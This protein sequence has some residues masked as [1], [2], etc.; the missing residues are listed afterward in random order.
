MTNDILYVM[1]ANS[2]PGDTPTLGTNVYDTVPTN[3]L[4]IT[5]KTGAKSATNTDTLVLTGIHTRA[6]YTSTGQSFI[7]VDNSSGALATNCFVEGDEIY[8]NA[9]VLLGDF[10]KFEDDD[11]GG[12]IYFAGT[13]TLVTVADNDQLRG[14]YKSKTQR[15]VCYEVR[16]IPEQS[17]G[18]LTNP[19][20]SANDG[21]S[22][23]TNGN[24]EYG[25]S[26]SSTYTVL[27]RIY[28]DS[29]VSSSAAQIAN[30]YLETR[31]SSAGN[32]VEMDTI[33]G[34]TIQL[35]STLAHA[36]NGIS[37]HDYFVLLWVDEG[38]KHHFAKITEITTSDIANDSF[39]FSPSYKSDIPKGTKYAI[40]RGP[41]V[42]DTNVVAVAYGLEGSGVGYETDWATNGTCD[43]VSGSNVVTGG[44]AIQIGYGGS[45]VVGSKVVGSG[46]PANTI[47]NS[48]SSTN[49]QI[50]LSQA[51]TAT[52]SNVTLTFYNDT[53]G[54]GAANDV[55]HSGLTYIARPNF[56]FYNDRLD[57]KNQLNHNTKYMLHCSRSDAS[58]TEQHFQ[59]CFVTMEDYS[60]RIVD[61]SK[62]SHHV[63]LRDQLKNCD[64]F[65]AGGGATTSYEKYGSS[66]IQE[67]RDVANWNNCFINIYRNEEDKK[68]ASADLNDS[69]GAQDFVGPKRY[70]HYAQSPSNTST[71]SN[72]MDLNIF[73]SVTKTGTYFTA[74][75]VDAQ[76]IISKKLKRDDE[77]QFYKVLSNGVILY[78]H[79]MSLFGTV[80]GTTS[81]TTL[82]FSELE[83]GQD[84]RLLLRSGSNYETISINKYVYRVTAV[85]AP[86][87]A[88]QTVTFD[89]Y[90]LS[91]AGSWTTGVSGAAETLTDATANRRAW[92]PITKTLMTTMNIDTVADYSGT[93]VTAVDDS[94]VTFTVG[95]A[96]NLSYTSTRLND[97]R[98][99]LLNGEQT[100]FRID[101][102]YGDKN[103]NFLKL[104]ESDVT[105]QLYRDQSV[106]T[107]DL[108][109][110]YEGGYV[111]EKP[112]F[113]GY[114][115]VMED[116][117]EDGLYMLKISGRNEVSKLL[118]PILNKNYNYSEDIIYSTAGPFVKL[119]DSDN[120]EAFCDSFNIGDTVLNMTAG[121]ALIEGDL[122]FSAGT[123]NG[124]GQGDLIGEVMAVTG[125]A[126]NQ[127]V[128]LLDGALANNTSF[129]VNEA[130]YNNDPTITHPANSEI[131]AGLYVS[132]TGIPS[133]STVAS[134]T[135]STH[136]ELSA[137]TTGGSKSDMTLTFTHPLQ[138]IRTHRNM[139]FAKAM[140]HSSYAN[141]TPTS[142]D[143][144]SSKGLIFTSG[145][146][147]VDGVESQT[148]SGTSLH[149]DKEAL[150]YPI[151]QPKGISNGVLGTSVGDSSFMCRL[152]GTI[153]GTFYSADFD[154][155][156]AISNFA[157]TDVSSD[158]GKGIIKLAPISPIV[159]GRVDGDITNG[160]SETLTNTN[161]YF[162]QEYTSMT[163]PSN[164]QSFIVSANC[165]SL[166]N[167]PIYDKD[168]KLFGILSHYYRTTA[169]VHTIILDRTPPNHT[170]ILDSEYI[171]TIDNPKNHSFALLNTQGINNGDCLH[172]M[173]SGISCSGNTMT[174]NHQ[175]LNDNEHAGTSG[176][177]SFNEIHGAPKYRIFDLHKFRP[178]AVFR[179]KKFYMDD[180]FSLRKANKHTY[181]NNPG[182]LQGLARAYKV[183]PLI[184]NSVNS[185]IDAELDNRTYAKTFDEYKQ[186]PPDMVDNKPILGSNYEDFDKYNIALST[187]VRV[188]GAISAGGNATITVDSFTHTGAWWDEGDYVYND[189]GEFLGVVKSLTATSIICYDTIENAV[190][191]NSYLWLAKGG[192][193]YHPL[194]RY[195]PKTQVGSGSAERPHYGLSDWTNHPLNDLLDTGNG[196][197]SHAIA[198]AKDFLEILDPK[199]TKYYLYGKADL[200][201]D[202][203]NRK[204]SLFYG[205][206]DITNYNLFLKSEGIEE[207]STYLPENYEG[208][209]SRH[210]YKD[211]SFETAIIEKSD[212]ELNELSRYNLMRL[213]EVTYDSQFNLIDPEYAP[214]KEEGV[215]AF[216]YTTFTPVTK[217]TGSST[218][219]F[220]TA[221]DSTTVLSVSGDY[222]NLANGDYIFTNDGV[223]IGRIHTS[224]GLNTPSSGKITLAAAR[225]Y[226]SNGQE[227]KG[228][229]YKITTNEYA[230][231]VPTPSNTDDAGYLRFGL[232]GRGGQN[233]ISGSTNYREY[234]VN[235]LQGAVFGGYRPPESNAIITAMTIHDSIMYP[236]TGTVN[237]NYDTGALFNGAVSRS[238]SSWSGGSARRIALD[239]VTNLVDK[240]KVGDGLY[241]ENGEYM[242][243]VS[244]VGST[245]VEI[246][247]HTGHHYDSSDDYA[248]PEHAATNNYAASKYESIIATSIGSQPSRIFG[249]FA[250]LMY[251]HTDGGLDYGIINSSMNSHAQYDNIAHP[252]GENRCVFIGRYDIPGESGCP[253]PEAIKLDVGSQAIIREDRIMNYAAVADKD[254]SNATLRHNKLMFDVEGDTFA[255]YSNDDGKGSGRVGLS[256][257]L[258]KGDGAYMVFKPI[259]KIPLTTVGSGNITRQYEDTWNTTFI[260]ENCVYNN[261][262]QVDIDQENSDIVAGLFVYGPGIPDGAYISSITNPTRFILSASTTGGSTRGTLA[263]SDTRRNLCLLTVASDDKNNSTNARWS[264]QA[265]TTTSSGIAMDENSWMDYAPNLTGYYLVSQQGKYTDNSSASFF[266]TGTIANA[267]AT[268]TLDAANYDVQVGM[269]VSGHGIPN[270]TKVLSITSSTVIEMTANATDNRNVRVYF[271]S[272]ERA[273]THASAAEV[274]PYHMSKIISHTRKYNDGDY[275]DIAVNWGNTN[276]QGSQSLGYTHNR[277]LTHYLLIDNP[278][279]S[280]HYNASG[281][282]LDYC[283]FRIMRPAEVCIHDNTSRAIKLYNLSSTTTKQA[284]RPDMYT[285]QIGSYAIINQ[286]ST[287]AGFGPDGSGGTVAV[288]AGTRTSNTY[289]PF[290]PT[291]GQFN[292]IIDEGEAILSMYVIVD[293][294]NKSNSN[295]L[296]PRNSSELFGD[297]TESK[298]FRLGGN[299]KFTFT[300]GNETVDRTFNVVAP[301]STSNNNGLVGFILNS[302]LPKML[303][304]VSFGTTFS[305]TT[306][307]AIINKD[308]ID[309]KI[310]T[311]LTICDEAE[312]II[313][314]MLELNDI[315][316]TD[317]TTEY[318]KYVAPNFQGTDLW[319]ASNYLAKL[320]DKKLLIDVD[321]IK[322]ES[323]NLNTR[324]TEIE[325]SNKT[326][327]DLDIISV[328]SENDSFSFYNHVTVYGRGV[329]STARNPSSIKKVGK[330]AY[331]E[332][333]EK[334][335][336]ET[337][338]LARA[339]TLLKAHN[340]NSRTIEIEVSYKGLEHIKAGDIVTV[341]LPDEN[342]PRAPY[343]I[344]EI[345]HSYQF[346]L[347]LKLGSYSKSMD[348]RLAEL[349]SENKKV[350]SFL[351]G[352]RFKGNTITNELVETIKVK[353]IKIRIKKTTTSATGTFIGFTSVM[354]IGTY[355]MGFTGLGQTT[356]TL[357]EEDL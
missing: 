278:P 277:T 143:N 164:G 221:Y 57:K 150:G 174:F 154:T 49:S 35:T 336:S 112:V 328:K 261:S 181:A 58:A 341:D 20:N 131:I 39:E 9:G 138:I 89:A 126:P 323:N 12:K 33:S 250:K 244:S 173:S 158:D 79:N 44:F 294:D 246:A 325:L 180:S 272:S 334:L 30:G 204:N 121:N 87:S 264:T 171:Y 23:G 222:N 224:A 270:N 199:V 239:D 282:N 227:Y 190:T 41:R 146:K 255:Y 54:T 115:E 229:L 105:Q 47:V 25:V 16:G 134:I 234:L 340:S 52:A 281:N 86:S 101:V 308:I 289:T 350:A 351:R 11:G 296:I 104:K 149:G 333:D 263:F 187:N 166:L 283:T 287:S 80:T 157:V 22:G 327:T 155:P 339:Q 10:S 63:V 73:E 106:A 51:A 76:R 161:I 14:L 258:W 251:I 113:D 353:P 192:T 130:S 332:F 200:Y 189:S 337:E 311:T 315:T 237:L 6:A 297:F 137:S 268:L 32:R 72:L 95:N 245:Y 66:N 163:H 68:Y 127:V 280:N 202:C 300:D 50:V 182:H 156:S 344:L 4:L 34:A 114:V 342:I 348:M 64:R 203:A 136:F 349:L 291:R 118:G 59:R 178:G 312:D 205:S 343:V 330:K 43:T 185:L 188:D 18:A 102:L 151:Y 7:L 82:T 62:Y 8:T 274:S 235:L 279:E 208:V 210:T 38:K 228:L 345:H 209:S 46:I 55:R 326:T 216:N 69:G 24:A 201:P 302:P 183:Q 172:H 132:G 109:T 284:F 320:K 94:L 262:T 241:N 124:L 67:V 249:R 98:I 169:G 110:Y 159:L 352:D 142:L 77:I 275:T 36:S 186:L 242:G 225:N 298:P 218:N 196:Y 15:V 301:T 103:N 1:S 206:R 184:Q 26:N 346:K 13:G 322:L 253:A 85:G 195:Y 273:N 148:L 256:T 19:F 313:E 293:P 145:K 135:D 141:L 314:N 303:G 265:V 288:T 84:L 310:G 259:L 207:T 212:K 338:T 266:T 96:S 356:V 267:D 215:D 2:K 299:Y 347:I 3:P 48:I 61:Y 331:E 306:P 194:W 133:L 193:D 162:T 233:T 153:D 100:G 248:N 238:E 88:T 236:V 74:T 317:S 285:K 65:G 129:E 128:T 97:T 198:V 170:T 335:G 354:N 271:N 232:I 214:K 111:I 5:K 70:I 295:F 60:Q 27:N 316:Y 286:E 305:I 219:P 31:E 304:A 93:S 92:S 223:L 177:T 90:K 319:S 56:Y 230:N 117:I 260:H 269:R 254:N 81:S 28:P 252:F 197:N 17:S 176:E 99:H 91:N 160:D 321:T 147:I 226:G 83:E 139:A 307:R 119:E 247:N 329:K 144:T 179:V 318:P 29:T 309:A 122:I 240:F 217:V 231:Q 116:F 120:H 78:K 167:K 140:S 108:L 290:V 257:G 324:F 45:L 75:I 107:R 40:W 53:D 357:L 123:S 213:I 191:D 276:S 220:I 355:T 168:G 165:K 175:V 152:S 243:L 71:I 42:T 21:S 211:D 125:T 37:A 292:D